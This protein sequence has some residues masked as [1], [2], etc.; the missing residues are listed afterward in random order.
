MK[1]GDPKELLLTMAE[2]HG[3]DTIVVGRSGVSNMRRLLAGSISNHLIN[4]AVC[5][6]PFYI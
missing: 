5:A 6:Y 1:Q 2:E 3:I 4:N